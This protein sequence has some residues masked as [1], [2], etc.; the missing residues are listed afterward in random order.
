MKK[1][2]ASLVTLIAVAA[3]AAGCAKNADDQCAGGGA[4]CRAKEAAGG[5][6]CG[7]C[8]GPNADK[9]AN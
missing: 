6:C 9:P 8:P 1:T 4:A 7:K 5:K 3:F 2:V